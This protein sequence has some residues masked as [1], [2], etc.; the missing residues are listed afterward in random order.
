VALTAA[1]TLPCL[2]SSCAAMRRRVSLQRARY[3]LDEDTAETTAARSDSEWSRA[4]LILRGV[5]HLGH[6]SLRSLRVTVLG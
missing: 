4:E 5:C 6:C 3:F 2:A 1:L